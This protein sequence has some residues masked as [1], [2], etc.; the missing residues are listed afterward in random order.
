MISR[1]YYPVITHPTR[2]TPISCTYINNI[3]CNRIYEIESTGVI[4]TNVSDHYPIFSTELWPSLADNVL[5]INYR[6]FSDENLSNFR[7][8]LQCTNWEPILNNAEANES[9]ELFQSTSLSNFNDHFPLQTK[10]VYNKADNKPW[11]N[12]G[13][14]TSIGAKR[15]LEKKCEVILTDVSPSIGGIKTSYQKLLVL[16]VT[17]II[18]PC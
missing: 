16:P 7:N 1:N 11:I 14:L 13:I 17:N 10:N 6:I 2:V 4:T 15:R 3:F 12:P 9:Y 18:V 8:S 5:S